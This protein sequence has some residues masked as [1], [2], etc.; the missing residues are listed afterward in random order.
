[1]PE[2]DENY[3][4][5]SGLQHLAF[6]PRQ[7]GL[8]HLEQV[9]QEN[10]LTAEGR[11]L[12]ERADLPGQTRR[13]QVRSVRGM[14]LRSDRLA[15]TGRADVVEFKPEPYPVEY[16][17]GKRKPND[18]DAVQLCAQ[19]LC[20]EEMLGVSIP[21]GA[22]F[23]GAPRRRLEVLFT[24]ELRRRTESLA[25]TMHQLFR[26]GTTPAAQPGPHCRN[27]SLVDICLPASTDGTVNPQKWL[28]RQL[29]SL[30][31]APV[32]NASIGGDPF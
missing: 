26:A 30:S 23:Y 11:L 24:I 28:E 7:W 29:R 21:K 13:D 8:I 9:W 6:C 3:L 27:C 32:D 10:L 19:A 4:P 31:T 16:K 12:H 1:M 17:R 5:I 22:F 20:L 15:L 14:W 2:F 18:C 25:A